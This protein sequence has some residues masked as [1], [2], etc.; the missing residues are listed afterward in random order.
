VI[1]EVLAPA[2]E[3]VAPQVIEEEGEKHR[4]LMPCLAVKKRVKNFDLVELS[5]PEAMAVEEAK[6]CLNCDLEE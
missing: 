3:A 1:D 6:R 5:M 4:P 2:E